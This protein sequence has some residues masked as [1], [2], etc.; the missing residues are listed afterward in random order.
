MVMV[1]LHYKKGIAILV[2]LDYLPSKI[3]LSISLL[4]AKLYYKKILH[5]I[6]YHLIAT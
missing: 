2:D 5:I 4:S 1:I 6:I 3:L